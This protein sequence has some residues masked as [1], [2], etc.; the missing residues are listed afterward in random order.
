MRRIICI[1]M[2][3]CM[4]SMASALSIT[5]GTFESGHASIWWDIQ[6]WFDYGDD[7]LEAPSGY[8]Q[9]TGGYMQGPFQYI[10]ASAALSIEGQGSAFC[11]ERV[12]EQEDGGNH[13][14]I[15]Q[16]IGIY[17]GSEPAIDIEIDWTVPDVSYASPGEYGVTMMVLGQAPDG[18]FEPNEWDGA[19]HDIYGFV[20][21]V[22]DPEDTNPITEIGRGTTGLR[23]VEKGAAPMH[24]RFQIDLSDVPIGDEL[25]LRINAYKGD[26]QDNDLL[27]PSE[28]PWVMMDNVALSIAYVLNQSPEDGALYVATE[29]DS[30]ENDLV[31]D[32]TDPA[33]IAVDVLFGP[34][35]DPN[36]STNPAYKIVDSMAVTQGQYTID[37]EAL[38]GDLAYNTTY[39]WKVLAYKAGDVTPSYTGL[40]T[41]FTTIQYGPLLTEVTPDIQGV[42][43]GDDAVFSLGYYNKTDTFQW[44]KEG[45]P[46]V[47]LTNGAKYAGVDSNS[48][49]ILDC[50]TADEGLYYCVGTETATGAT[51]ASPSGALA[52]KELR[53]YYP[54]D[55]QVGGFTPDTI[56]GRNAQLMG[57]AS[58]VANSLPGFGNC[59]SLVNP[60]NLANPGSP[61]HTQY[62]QIADNDV[63]LHKEITISCWVKP[64]LLDTDYERWARIFD[65]GTDNDDFFYLTLLH[66]TNNARCEMFFTDEDDEVNQQDLDGRS[67]EIGYGT[68][69]LYVVLTI[70]QNRT[71]KIYI[72]GRHV[73]EGGLFYPSDVDVTYS[74]IGK[75]VAT[76]QTTLFRS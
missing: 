4:V 15:Y 27:N 59:L 54:F 45:T 32:I 33:I 14:Y 51:A 65:F 74:Y 71:G 48:L 64:T 6:D 29:L 58:L 5:N 69:W 1:L 7:T 19:A 8:N 11:G 49:T 56:G 63:A 31:F 53:A 20:R 50:Q 34:E 23:Y 61:V 76:P 55:S 62:A 18:P 41:S 12:R 72:N 60:R 37:L 30:P 26:L 44:Y 52:I 28:K 43:A 22:D 47:M 25:F 2:C 36:L 17:D 42:W 3:L 38:A 73:G 13:A 16:S 39:T 46:D 70:D 67:S 57:G 75:A 10:G 24:D 40:A 66:G 9:T 21:D 68:Q 35:N